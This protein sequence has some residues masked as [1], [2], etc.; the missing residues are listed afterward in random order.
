[1]RK[2]MLQ[3]AVAIA[4]CV[5]AGAGA[6]G[7]RLPEPPN[8]IFGAA[9]YGDVALATGEVTAVLAGETSPAARYALGADSRLTCAAGEPCRYRYALWVPFE[10]PTSPAEP[11]T[12][13]VARAGDAVAVYI[14]GVLAGRAALDARGGLI[15]LGLDSCLEDREDY[16]V[17]ADGDGY[18]SPVPVNYC[19][20]QEPA[21]YALLGHWS[22]LD[23]N[24][25]VATTFPGATE[26]CNGV[27]DNCDGTRDG[28]H[29]PVLSVSPATHDY[30]T[31]DLGRTS[32]AQAF[33]VANIGGQNLSL[34]ALSIAGSDAADYAI[35][36]NGCTGASLAPGASCVARLAFTPLA[37]GARDSAWLR[38][39]SNDLASDPLAARLAGR[40]E[41]D[42][43]GDGVPYATDNCPYAANPDQADGDGDGVGDA[44][45]QMYVLW[46]R[47]DTGRALLWELN[48]DAAAGTPAV[49][50][51]T[52]WAALGPAAGV[53][54]PW[55]AT[56][57]AQVSA[58]EAYALWTRSDTGRAVLWK[59]DPSAAGGTPAAI[60]IVQ[61]ASVFSTTGVGSPWQATSYSQVSPSEAYVLWSRADTGRAVLWRIDPSAATATSPVIPVVESLAIGSAAGAGAPWLATAYA[62]VSATE[63]YVLWSRADTGRAVLWKIDPS[64][65]SGTPAAIRVVEIANIQ[66]T[67]GV[68]APWQ[69]TGYARVSA[70]EAHVLWTRADTGRAVVWKINPG[71]AAGSPR[72]IPAT[73][74]T[75]LRSLGGEGAPW[76]ATSLL[77]ARWW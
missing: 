11:R 65:T 66:S 50:P 15:D 63:A 75:S 35:T 21:G 10:T 43:D 31:V 64:A 54:A 32:A 7:A 16:Y 14:D 41:A 74:I 49:I 73:S 37:A 4:A 20:G 57:Y 1:M 34:T 60:P 52:G 46:S 12:A 22:G 45:E 13:G 2:L 23:C 5:L 53:G 29:C 28:V 38:V 62:H 39:D 18:A 6:A 26:A 30:G 67:S 44:C 47:A 8:V 72:V 71:A 24:D 77:P 33:R 70:T 55:L 19:P 76:Q 48:P 25:A 68:G 61:T 40:G 3:Q 58:S 56:G 51:V 59:L 69:A 42:P 36:A 17:D 9:M 27:D